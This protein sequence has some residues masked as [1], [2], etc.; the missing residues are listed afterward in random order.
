MKAQNNLESQPLLNSHERPSIP[1]G[2]HPIETGDYLVDTTSINEMAEH[3]LYWI[4]SRIP[5]AIVYGP[6]RIGKSR[7]IKYLIKVF[8]YKYPNQWVNL[9]ILT[10]YRKTPNEDSFFEFFLKD[11][12]HDLFDSGK[13]TAKRNRLLN[14]LLDRGNRTV[15][16][17]IVLFVDDAQRLTQPYY[18]WLMD[19]YNELDNY[20]ITLTTILVGQTELSH[21]RNSFLTTHKQ[22]VGRF[23][24]NEKRFYGIKSIKELS[25]LL[26]S[27]DDVT[28][29]PVG[30]AWSFTRFFFPVGFEK[31]YR[32]KEESKNLWN[33]IVELRAEYGVNRELEVPMHYLI[34]IVN[35]VFMRYGYNEEAI[36][37][38]TLSIW[39]EAIS[40]TGY[41]NAEVL[42]S[43][44][45]E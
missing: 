45:T 25:Y 4:N 37:W 1:I 2:G 5:G 43:S 32:M 21:R 8:E 42:Q 19:V 31:G 44:E 22:I 36:E 29:Y 14:F 20:G 7:A 10:R 30:S 13:A 15:R 3:M 28:E 17:Q 41:L 18:D 26:S 38:P 24:I 23:M 34:S 39:K 35:Y 11:V 16:N 33:T 9:N 27:F 40:I 6:P 12:G